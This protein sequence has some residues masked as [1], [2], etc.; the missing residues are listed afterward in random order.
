MRALVASG[1]VF[2]F[3]K[4]QTPALN[5]GRSMVPWTLNEVSANFPIPFKLAAQ[6]KTSPAHG[7]A[8]QSTDLSK[9]NW[10]NVTISDPMFDMPAYVVR[11]PSDWRFEGALLRTACE[12]AMLV[13]RAESPDGLTGVQVMPKVHWTYAHDP[14]ALQTANRVC[15]IHPPA[16]AAKQAPE[17]AAAAR[18]QSQLGLVEPVTVPG[19]AEMYAKNNQAYKNQT[20]ANGTPNAA[21]HETGDAA[22][23][24][25]RYNYQGHAEEEWISVSTTVDDARV[26]VAGTGPNGII[27]PEWAHAQQTDTLVSGMRAPQG[28]LDA[29]MPLLKGILI[30]LVPEYDQAVLAFNNQQFQQVQALVRKMFEGTLQQGQQAHHT[31]MAQHAA[32]L[33]WQQQR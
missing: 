4:W 1:V 32:Y 5:T 11:I 15:G 23:V 18:P 17:I 8:V 28:S 25:V 27:R 30:K 33:Q 2:A 21:L 19:A 16:P 7:S 12:G 31:L 24:R 13:Y 6:V 9:I 14:R 29:A 22:R 3:A 10:I 26:A 20:R